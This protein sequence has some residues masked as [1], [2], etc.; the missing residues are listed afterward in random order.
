MN[1][2]VDEIREILKEEILTK[3][4]LNKEI[5]INEGMQ[6]KVEVAIAC[7]I[8]ES[9]YNAQL[10]IYNG[11]AQDLDRDKTLMNVEYVIDSIEFDLGRIGLDLSN[12]SLTIYKFDFFEGVNKVV[13]IFEDN[14]KISI[15]EPNRLLV[16]PRTLSESIDQIMLFV[17][18]K[19]LEENKEKYQLSED[20]IEKLNNDFDGYVYGSLKDD[21]YEYFLNLTDKEIEFMEYCYDIASEIY[22]KQYKYDDPICGE[23]IF[24]NYSYYYVYGMIDVDANNRFSSISIPFKVFGDHTATKQRDRKSVV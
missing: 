20:F 12:V 14:H 21:T 1:K 7:S 8:E 6:F 9:M 10:I 18:E 2:S 4:N 22:V 3:S 24:Y 19:L 15:E 16:N 17:L 13:P 11:K 23:L 5:I